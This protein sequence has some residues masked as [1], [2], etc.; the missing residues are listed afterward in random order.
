MAL[1]LP[2]IY[3]ITPG[4][5]TC[6]SDV[7]EVATRFFAAGIRFLQ[8]REKNLADRELLA[9]VEAAD[10]AGR[11][12]GATVVVNDR[13]DVA[14]VAAVGVH[15]GENDL[16]APVARQLLAAGVV[17]G[18]STHDLPAARAA[19][20][21]SSCDYVAFGPV[22]ESATKPGRSSRGVNA[23]AAVAR[24]KTRPLVAVGG[25]T[26]E[27]LDSVFDAGADSAAMVGALAAG[28][29]LE[30]NARRALDRA[31]RRHPAGRIYLVGFMGTG[32]TALGRRI[33][34]RLGIPFVDL[35][36]EIERTS[37][38]TI[39]ALFE[40][41]GEPAFRERESTFLG[42]TEALPA[43]VVSTGGGSF[44]SERNRA[45]IARL[46]TPVFL[47]VPFE[48]VRARLSG[49]TDRPLFTSVEQAA[50]LFAE[51]EPFYRMAPVRVALT[52]RESIEEST[53][54]VLS[55]VY[56]RRELGGPRLES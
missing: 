39:R 16:P 55:A 7:S 50:R 6:G 56:D 23:L 3:A 2:P 43:A 19:F 37:G 41:L 8:I 36:S 24:E 18:V 17:V 44:V 28:G 42:G 32:K 53:D 11:K 21:D 51:R 1:R 48:A 31:R 27:N 46:G 15:L 29:R 14:R 5:A 35:D 54:K 40:S 49:K 12:A 22:F 45:T 52:G 10:Q 13:L 33:S 9:G 34:E 47:D 30:E 20:G 26:E 25:I 4:A 38:L